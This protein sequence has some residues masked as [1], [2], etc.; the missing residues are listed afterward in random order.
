MSDRKKIKNITKLKKNYFHLNV[1]VESS[2]KRGTLV[3]SNLIFNS[4]LRRAVVL[5]G[6]LCYPGELEIC[7]T[8][9]AV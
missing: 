5:W 1:L 4:H 9:Y 3:S 7:G 8:D 2:R 6:G